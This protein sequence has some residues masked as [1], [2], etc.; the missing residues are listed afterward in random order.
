MEYVLQTHALTKIYSGRKVVNQ[1][2]MHVRRGD[3]YGFIGKNGAGKT[4]FM[5]LVTGLAQPTAGTLTLFDGKKYHAGGACTGCSIESPALYPNLTAIQNLEVF[6]RTLGVPEKDCVEKLLAIT[7]LQDTG[8]K[9]VRHFSMGMKQRLSIAIAL[10]GSPDFLILDEPINGLDPTGIRDIR[11]LL[12]RLNK[13]HGITLLISS[14]ILG[15]LSKIA[16]CYGVINQGILVDEFTAQEL[17]NRCR[18]CLR[19]QV[20]DVKKA[21]CILETE[22]GSMQY[23]VLPDGVI[24]LF[25]HLDRPAEI[26]AALVSRGINVSALT[27]TGQDLEG[28]FMEL[29]GGAGKC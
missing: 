2:N 5:R 8:K 19:I 21:C 22:T 9:T 25:D 3:I 18:R 27:L 4:T 20:D 24:R 26:N 23:D 14:H 16:T 15:E 17:Q 10:L 6:R 12:V 28:Y 1:V 13:E 29:M 11:D 7:G